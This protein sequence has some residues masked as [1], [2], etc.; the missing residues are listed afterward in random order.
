MQEALEACCWQPA[1]L[2]SF[3]AQLP[4][5]GSTR[6]PAEQPVARNSR[7]SLAASIPS[8]RG[9][10]TAF[11]WCLQLGNAS[12]EDLEAKE[13]EM[14]VSLPGKQCSALQVCSYLHYVCATPHVA[15]A[16]HTQH[17]LPSQ[18]LC[19]HVLPVSDRAMT[20]LMPPFHV[21]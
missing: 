1:L 5:A 14:R 15:Q 11:P 19:Q 6:S 16:C 18:T 3:P 17:A 7:S 13:A 21:L 20:A 8:C 2:A 4:A 10:T 9:H 12:R